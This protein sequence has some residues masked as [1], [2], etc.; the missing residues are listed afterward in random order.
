MR[1]TRRQLKQLIEANF[2]D[3]PSYDIL[4]RAK[5]LKTDFMSSTL[6][7]G[8]NEWFAVHFFGGYKYDTYNSGSGKWSDL[9][10]YLEENLGRKN[11][12]ELSGVIYHKS[13]NS[14]QGI[15]K[16]FSETRIAFVL[17]GTITS[18]YKSDIVSTKFKPLTA[19]GEKPEDVKTYGFKSKDNGFVKHPWDLGTDWLTDSSF[20]ILEKKKATLKDLQK[21][22]EEGYRKQR[23]YWECFIDN[24]EIVSIIDLK[25]NANDEEWKRDIQPLL[26]AYNIPVTGPNNLIY[27]N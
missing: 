19:A 7:V 9:K 3:V 22:K 17:K 5:K 10:N 16:K 2:R 24:H 11:R 6:K 1:I 4:N 21:L 25:G 8:Q 26:D 18:A 23:G 27:S 15:E 12:D 13:M 14:L 20:N